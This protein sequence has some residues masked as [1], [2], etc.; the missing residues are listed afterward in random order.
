MQARLLAKLSEQPE[1]RPSSAEEEVC[2]L[3]S[4][5]GGREATVAARSAVCGP[6]VCK[7]APC[8]RAPPVRPTPPRRGR[9]ASHAPSIFTSAAAV[10]FRIGNR[11][12]TA[13]SRLPAIS[14]RTMPAKVSN[15]HPTHNTRTLD[16]LLF[17]SASRMYILSFI[18]QCVVCVVGRA[19]MQTFPCGHRVLCRKCFIRTIQVSRRQGTGDACLAADDGAVRSC[20]M[21]A[22]LRVP[23]GPS[24]AD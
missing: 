4:M 2:L 21:D 14:S 19:C 8:G 9:S 16:T 23:S 5:L 10:T 17:H 7:Y 3:A 1:D 20:I 13:N 15:S 6:T 12:G 24:P 18:F 11:A 22:L